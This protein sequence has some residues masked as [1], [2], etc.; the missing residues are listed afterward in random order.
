MADPVS[1]VIENIVRAREVI[2]SVV[3]TQIPDEI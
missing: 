2:E 1:E 3:G